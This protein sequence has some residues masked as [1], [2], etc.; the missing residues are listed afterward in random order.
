MSLLIR[1]FWLA[2]TW[3]SRGPIDLLAESVLPL[4]VLPNDLDVFGHMNNGRYLAIMDLG[5][6]D[7]LYRTGSMRA[8][9]DRGW[10]PLVA[11]A[12]IRYRRP[13]MLWQFYTLHTRL[14]GWDDKWLFIEQRFEREGQL[15]AVA[16]VKGLFAGREGKVPTAALLQ[17]IG[18]DSVSPPLPQDLLRWAGKEEDT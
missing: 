9:R 14:L 16:R 11:G 12:R 13:L 17:A 8:T 10:H 4:R 18:L 5:R 3:R 1:L 7:Y 15:V 2:V 6:I